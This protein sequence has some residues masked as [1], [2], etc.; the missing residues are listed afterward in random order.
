M[1]DRLDYPESGID[2]LES[3]VS[4][5]GWCGG[6]LNDRHHEIV[7]MTGRLIRERT[8]L[9]QF[10]WLIEALCGESCAD[11]WL[12]DTGI[13]IES[14]GAVDIGRCLSCGAAVNRHARHES[15]WLLQF[16]GED[17]E[18]EQCIGIL[19]GNCVAS[20]GPDGDGGLPLPIAA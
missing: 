18:S 1:T 12:T 10:E 15:V 2:R 5:C 13:S 16:N 17:V 20:G 11:S 3:D 8:T 14:P 19:C 4:A 6:A 9:V 7:G